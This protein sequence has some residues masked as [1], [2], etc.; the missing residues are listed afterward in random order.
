MFENNPTIV[1]VNGANWIGA[2][3]VKVITSNK[4]NV[5]VIDDFNNINIP[6]IK[7][8][9]DNKKFAFIERDKVHSISTN[10]SKIKYMIHLKNDFDSVNDEIS[11]KEFIKETKFIDEILSIALEKNSCYILTTSMHL[12]KDF[13][14]KQSHPRESGSAY[15]ESDLQDY[16]ERTVV[17]YTKK[18]GLNGRIA[19][20]GNIYGP[21]MPIERDEVLKQV[22]SDAIFKEE[23]RIFGDGLE[24]MYYVY[25]T[26]AVQGILKALFSSDTKG[27]IYSITNPE[28]ISILS[29]VNKL[30]GLQPK[31]KKI[32]FL[33]PKSNSD[34]LYERAYIPD[35]NVTEIG[36]KPVVSFERGLKIILEYF[37]RE[38]SHENNTEERIQTSSLPNDEL[39]INFNVVDNTTHLIDESNQF[40]EFYKKLNSPDSPIYNIKEKKLELP[41]RKPIETL[42]PTTSFEY[43][44]SGLVFFLTFIVIGF[45][46]VPTVNLGNYF[47]EL[48]EAS[49]QIKTAIDDSEFKYDLKDNN[50]G[51][52]FNET[53]Y[54]IE[55]VFDV[56]SQ[57]QVVENIRK[58]SIGLDRAEDAYQFIQKERLGSYLE[59][60]SKPIQQS[61]I[62]KV[63]NLVT[64]LNSADTNLNNSN[65]N[66]PFDANSNIEEIHD[67]VIETRS[68]FENLLKA[69]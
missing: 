3:L 22:F 17:E 32:R 69:S 50:L 15:N 48:K 40:N 2:E 25:I 34:P 23:I 61:D 12:H 46:T 54:P 9:S 31:A 11:S 28:E 16:M 56:V 29:L 62:P 64:I 55:W 67:W 8:F 63:N 36:W 7:R 4:G 18:A 45:I 5:I 37:L 39:S 13:I 68:H 58:T 65:L 26:D 49:T 38:S 20:L 59:D 42:R 24:Y 27:Q 10:F 1:I 66:L 53:T 44:K 57:K 14:L 51:S 43:I 33:K 30:L 52:R 35:P 47:F 6:F 60:T 41:L 21:E 19:R